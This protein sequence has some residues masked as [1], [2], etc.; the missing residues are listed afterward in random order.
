MIVVE[1]L[2]ELLL[3]LDST[4]V[5]RIVGG[6]TDCDNTKTKLNKN[7]LFDVQ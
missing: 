1:N 7:I 6:L 5:Q 4:V 2:C 3:V